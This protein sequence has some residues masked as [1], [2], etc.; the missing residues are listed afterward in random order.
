MDAPTLARIFEPFFTTKEVGKGTGLGLSTVFGIVQQS[1][2]T[3]AVDSEVGVGTAFEILFP[4]A[5]RSKADRLPETAQGPGDTRGTETILLVEDD[6]QVRTLT[7]SLLR[8]SGYQVLEASSG[9]DALLLS[10]QHTSA[11]DLLLTDVVMPRLSGRELAERLA[12]RRPTMRALYMSG[13]TNDAVVRHG[14]FEANADLL[15]KPF[16]PDALTRMVRSV[17]DAARRS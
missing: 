2:G 11:I 6:P 14:V 1:G 8:R 10:D 12:L 7:A 17:L 3:I 5:S 15:Q 9:G 4:V 13:Y 16:T